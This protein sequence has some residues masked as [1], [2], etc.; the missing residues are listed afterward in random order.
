MTPPIFRVLSLR[1]LQDDPPEFWKLVAKEHEAITEAVAERDADA[2]RRDDEHSSLFAAGDIRGRAGCTPKA[3]GDMNQSLE[4]QV[5]IVTGAARGIGRAFCQALAA[6]GV[7]IVACDRCE[8]VHEVKG[9]TYVADVGH[10]ADVRSVVDGAV[11]AHGRVDILV[12]NACAC[13]I[14]DSGGRCVVCVALERSGW[15]AL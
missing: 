8:A 7:C 5:A 1:Y 9:L 6:E 2:G 3:R 13:L 4:G 11:A 15:L 14:N 10:P 12:N